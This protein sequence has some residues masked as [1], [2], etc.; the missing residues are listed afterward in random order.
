[1]PLIAY[2]NA[3]GANDFPLH[4]AFFEAIE[5][6]GLLE[7]YDFALDPFTDVQYCRLL[8]DRFPQLVL[9]TQLSLISRARETVYRTLG[10][11]A[12]AVALFENGFDA[13][14]E[15]PGGRIH[16]LYT[17]GLDVFWRYPRTRRRAILFHSI[18]PGIADQPKTS[19]S[20]AE[21]DL[22]I[23]RSRGAAAVARRVGSSRV[24]ESCDIV[25]GIE[26]GTEY[27]S[28]LAIALRLP[29]HGTTAEYL[30]EIRL[31]LDYLESLG[32]NVDH[33]RIESP[34]GG[35]QIARGYGSAAKPNIGLWG[36]AKLYT[37]FAIKRD[38]IV[39]CRLHTTLMAIL[40]GNRKILQF[41]IETGTNK[42]AEIL[43]DIGLSQLAVHPIQDMRLNTIRRF[44]ESHDQLSEQTVTDALAKA[45][46]R[47]NEG[48]DAFEEWLSTL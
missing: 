11:G 21:T 19:R 46:G 45:R 36:D 7:K 43:E 27:R 8:I 47:I 34:M 16:P 23:A 18:E 38:G 41:Q 2:Q 28:G 6:R 17:G 39:S 32:S 20:I 48:L 33:V 42:I 40:A 9:T 37:P 35:E 29:N 4:F 13:V 26:S 3:H 31:I 44:V 24:V 1:M 15:A 22:V 12:K 10:R 14:C 25:L 30:Q 5:R